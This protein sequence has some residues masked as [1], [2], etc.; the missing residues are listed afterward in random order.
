VFLDLWDTLYTRSMGL[1]MNATKTQLLLSANAGK[2]SEVTVELE[3][4]T[5]ISPGT[6]IE[7]LGVR[8]DRKLLMTP[9]IMSW[10]AAV[11]QRA[12]IVAR[13]A[14]HLPGGRTCGNYHTG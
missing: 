4:K 6:T 5:I 8:Y 7:F 13:L 9:Q 1:S 11:R 10:L 2:V 14:N 12:L 3:G